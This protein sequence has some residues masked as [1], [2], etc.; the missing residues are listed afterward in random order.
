MPLKFC[1]GGFLQ[2]YNAGM[3][4]NIK[5]NDLLVSALFFRMVIAAKSKT[6]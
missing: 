5:P 6:R 1:N 3:N 2:I 4:L